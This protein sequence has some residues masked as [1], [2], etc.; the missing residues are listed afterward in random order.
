MRGCG[1]GQFWPN[2]RLLVGD[3]IEAAPRGLPPVAVPANGWSTGEVSG[4]W[5]LET[6]LDR[7]ER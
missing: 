5:R 4:P 6:D 7:G 1:F 2:K 3:V